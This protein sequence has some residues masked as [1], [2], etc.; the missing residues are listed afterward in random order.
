MEDLLSG[1][2]KSMK[3]IAI[4]E[5]TVNK[6][7]EAANHDAIASSF[8]YYSVFNH[9]VPSFHISIPD[10]FELGERRVKE[11]DMAGIDMEVLSYVN[12]TQWLKGNEALTLAKNANDALAQNVKAFPDRFLGFATLPWN[13]PKAA[14]E[15]LRHTINE[16]GFVG[17]LLSGRPQTA[18]IYA[19]DPMYYPIWEVLTEYDLPVYVHP[20]YTS[21]DA[22]KAYYS[23]LSD[24]VN[25]IFS[26]M[27]YGW[28]MEAGIQVIRMI[29]A[30]VFEKFPNL[31]VISG[32]WGEM[33]PF[34]L[35][36]LDHMMARDVTGLPEDFST[37]YKRNVWVT[38]GGIYDNDDLM[39]CVN[40]VGIDHLLF[41][42]DF[43][44]IP[45]A[46]AKPFLDNAPLS[47][48]DKEKFAHINAETLLHLK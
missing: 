4:E 24:E 38:P 15:E 30:G 46:G 28:H 9:P 27:G 47:E 25:A 1:L 6:A 33:V 32:H 37:Y 17:T 43:P 29:L 21:P 22:C 36:R 2:Q 35:S 12:V 20:H 14:A 5:H 10:L 16:Y 44:Y 18:N 34:Y 7:I 45:L 8:P 42:T 26:T 40:K 19:D 13:N 41:A 11:L 31:K 48:T 23:G 3:I 39:F